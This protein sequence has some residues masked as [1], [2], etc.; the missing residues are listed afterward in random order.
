M[1]RL[2]GVLAAK[3]MGAAPRLLVDNRCDGRRT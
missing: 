1:I 3:Q 2:M